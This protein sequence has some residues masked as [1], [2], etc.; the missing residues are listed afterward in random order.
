MRCALRKST[1]QLQCARSEYPWCISI[2]NFIF[3]LC[4]P[5]NYPVLHVLRISEEAEKECV[6]VPSVSTATVNLAKPLSLHEP[7]SLAFVEG[8]EH[9][10]KS[11]PVQLASIKLHKST[12]LGPDVYLMQGKVIW[13]TA[14]C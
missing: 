1:Q 9:P 11:R 6:D 8:C 2:G 14:A 12:E 13:T 4:I 7:K 5:V 3:V 10:D